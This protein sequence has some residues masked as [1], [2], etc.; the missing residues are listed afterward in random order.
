MKIQKVI[1]KISFAGHVLTFL[2]LNQVHHQNKID[3]N[4]SGYNNLGH[5]IIHYVQYDFCKGEDSKG[6]C[7]Q[8]KQR[9]SKI[10]MVL[11]I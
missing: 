10:L 11:M 3:C 9:S 8:N 5:E 1:W 7:K 2:F 4:F 6:L